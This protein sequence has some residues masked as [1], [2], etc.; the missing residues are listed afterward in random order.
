[1]NILHTISTRGYS[2]IRF[3]ALKLEQRVIDSKYSNPVFEKLKICFL[4]GI[5]MYFGRTRLE[6]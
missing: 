3:I 6:N 4:I 1:M 2:I 5:Y